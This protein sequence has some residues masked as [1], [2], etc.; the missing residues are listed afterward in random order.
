MMANNE[1]KKLLRNRKRRIDRG[2]KINNDMKL[3]FN[4]I[5]SE[6]KKKYKNFEKSKQLEILLVRIKN[7]DNPKKLENALKELNKF[8]VINKNLHEIK[9]EILLDYVGA[10][11]MVGNF[12]VGD[13]IR[14]TNF[15]FKNMDE[16]EAD[17]NSIDEGYHAEDVIFNGYI[18]IINT[19]QFNKVN[20]SH[21]GNGCDF[22]HEIIKYRG[23]N[24]FKPTKAYCFVN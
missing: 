6:K 13:Q 8:Q 17:I 5:K 24:C 20:R 18:Y 7:A 10:F 2:N 14:R 12:K 21:Y 19:P 4:K 1:N 16:F 11:E 9:N 15:R 23:N 22:E 3:L